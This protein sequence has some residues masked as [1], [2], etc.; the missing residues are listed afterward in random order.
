MCTHKYLYMTTTNDA[1]MYTYFSVLLERILQ[2]FVDRVFVTLSLSL[3]TAV[4]IKVSST[5][6]LLCPSA[7][8]CHF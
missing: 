1:C 4:F 7:W 2:L 3:S 8:S 5:P 6:L